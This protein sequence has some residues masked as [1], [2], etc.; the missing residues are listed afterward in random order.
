MGYY[1]YK[2]LNSDME[3]IY[4][5]QTKN[6]NMRQGTHT[7]FEC[8]HKI[9]FIEVETK[10]IMDLYEKFYISKYKPMFNK[11]DKDCNYTKY[12]VDLEYDFKEYKKQHKDKIINDMLYPETFSIIKII[13]KS[14]ELEIPKL[15]TE[16]REKLHITIRTM[17]KNIKRYISRNDNS[18][19]EI[20][21][22]KMLYRMLRIIN[23]GGI[24]D[25]KVDLESPPRLKGIKE[26]N[27][28]F[29]FGI[30]IKMYY[31]KENIFY[32]GKFRIVATKDEMEEIFI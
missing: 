12:L 22:L 16:L 19:V 29:N 23:Y 21:R 11:K 20:F 27:Y 26:I 31:Y 13:L 1:I 24:R 30:P 8:I 15:S 17:S 14:S 3:V 25:F 2:H 10:E 7:H 32:V 5:G 18:S 4:I 28:N 9:L 6:M